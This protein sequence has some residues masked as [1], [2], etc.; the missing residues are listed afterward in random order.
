MRTD[1]TWLRSGP[2]PTEGPEISTA[3]P[4]HCWIR[5]SSVNSRMSLTGS[6]STAWTNVP[7]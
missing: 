1:T 3:L 4:V 5:F 7:V 6:K 2:A